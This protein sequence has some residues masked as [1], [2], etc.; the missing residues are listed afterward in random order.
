MR[1]SS[2]RMSSSVYCRWCFART[3]DSASGLTSSDRTARWPASSTRFWQICVDRSSGTTMTG[4]CTSSDKSTV[5]WFS[6]AFS[7]PARVSR[8]SPSSVELATSISAP[9]SS[10]S[11]S[12]G[13]KNRAIASMYDGWYTT[14]VE[15]MRNWSAES[16]RPSSRFCSNSVKNSGPL[17]LPSSVTRTIWRYCVSSDVAS[18]T[19]MPPSDSDAEKLCGR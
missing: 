15:R 9:I 2:C 16:A 18:S 13:W 7:R 19:H 3:S 5:R 8:R 1:S 11:V 6:S 10:R 4:A 17:S 12:G 14:S